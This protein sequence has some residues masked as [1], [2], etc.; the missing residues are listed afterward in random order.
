MLPTDISLTQINEL[1]SVLLRCVPGI[2]K[3][4]AVD[5]AFNLVTIFGGGSPGVKP[6]EGTKRSDTD[7]PATDTMASSNSPLGLGRVLEEL[8]FLQ[9]TLTRFRNNLHRFFETDQA[10]GNG[11]SVV[12][13]LDLGRSL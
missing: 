7:Q 10:G 9:H 11:R 4:Q 13:S 2:T 3:G 8:D 1:E 6:E 12:E 5:L